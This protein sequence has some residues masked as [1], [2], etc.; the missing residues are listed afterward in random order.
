MLVPKESFS[1]YVCS[2]MFG[3]NVRKGTLMFVKRFMYGMSIHFNI[4]HTLMKDRISYDLNHTGIINIKMS[5]MK[6][7]KTKLIQ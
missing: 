4:F 1:E 3:R 6:L 5:G 2:L 7:R